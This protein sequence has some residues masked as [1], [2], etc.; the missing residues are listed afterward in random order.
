MIAYLKGEIIK[1]TEKGIILDTGNVGYF[2]NLSNSDLS[3]EQQDKSKNIKAE[4]FI[5]SHIREAA[6]DLYGFSEYKDLE[7]FRLLLSINGIGP[8]AAIEI[9][10]AGSDKVKAAIVNEDLAL[11]KS[12]NGI[13]PKTAKRIILELKGKIP[14]DSASGEISSA[15]TH[16]EAFEALAQLGYK[17]HHVSKIISG[18]PVEI[19]ETEEIITFFLR[20]N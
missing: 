9:L 3:L 11:I 14:E 13:G 4:Y 10:S 2:V 19:T 16:T 20:N 5:H 18:M 1:R 6:F 7:F 8:K 12:I 15:Q 17:R